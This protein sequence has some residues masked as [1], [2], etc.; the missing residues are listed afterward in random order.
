MITFVDLMAAIATDPSS[1][2]RSRTASL[3]MSDTTR[4]GPHW[5]STCAI[6]ESVRTSVTRP[7][8]RFRAELDSHTGNGG[9]DACSRA[10][11]ATS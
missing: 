1:S 11:F 4:N 8:K 7:T 3:D 5:S 9:G 6:T 10:T 2:P